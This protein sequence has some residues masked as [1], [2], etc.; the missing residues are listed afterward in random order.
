MWS[1]EELQEIEKERRAW[2]EGTLAKTMQ[3]FGVQ[4]SPEK[5][6][7]P[8][9]IKNH[10]FL[11]DVGFPGDY[12]YTSGTYAMA[13]PIEGLKTQAT[14]TLV[15]AGI[16]SGYGTAEDTRDYYKLIQS[17]GFPGGPNIAFDLPTQTGL[18]SDDPRARGEVG[19]VGV[20]V[21]TFREFETIYESFTDGKDLD[22]IASNFTVNAMADIIIA[23]YA[24]LAEKRRI[25]PAKLKGTPQNDIL[26]EF[27]ARGTQVFPTKPSMRMTR[28]SITYCTENMPSLN[29]VNVCGYHIREAGATRE[30]T[31]AFTFSNA[32]AYVQLG[33]DAGLDVDS[34]VNRFAF[35]SFGGGMEILKEIAMFR[36][37]RR[38]WAKIMRERFNAKN[39]RSWLL[40]LPA[41]TASIGCI[42]TT[43]QR[44]LNN[45]TRAVLGG[46]A[47]AMSGGSPMGFPPFDEPL[48]LGWSL[49]ALQLTQDAMRIMTHEAKLAE[50]ID[51]FA[52][53]YY[54]EAMTDEIE[55]KA[56]AII[57]QIDEMGGA[58][59]AIEKG[60][61]QRE[62][63]KSAHAFQKEIE[64]GERMVVGVNCFT[65]EQE[66]EVMPQRI[67]PDAYDPTKRAEAEKKQVA[68]LADTKKNRDNAAVE[69]SLKRLEDAAREE[70]ANVIPP[71]KECVEAYASIGEMT[72][73]LKKVFGEHQQYGNL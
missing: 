64:T 13:S 34:F 71:L 66:L 56:W 33:I 61:M 54:M 10:D 30:Q 7:T 6:Y 35:L 59:V 14:G 62:I 68:Q 69:A 41:Y 18:D 20:A 58:V 45:H 29:T 28:D 15:R 39:P 23:M 4:Q 51:P 8:L 9:D 32:I 21:D 37:A 12:P 52:G 50:V 46:V 38:M 70:S 47:S 3:R 11:R 27:V 31:L 63:A 44:P 49:E 40:R 19:K 36:A 26:K 73:T 43:A 60:W 22:K 48:G 65:G 24:A 1:S 42:S 25:S 55:E 72:G 17:R 5:F 2:E 57:K 53:S 67:V 16:Y